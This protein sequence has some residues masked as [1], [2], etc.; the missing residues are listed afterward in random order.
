MRR[1]VPLLAASRFGAGRAA[2]S[3]PRRPA[4]RTI[5]IYAFNGVMGGG[6]TLANIGVAALF[7]RL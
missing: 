3:F 7:S 4:H 2:R 6:V 1:T 5:F